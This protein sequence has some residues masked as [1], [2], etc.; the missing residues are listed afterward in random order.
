MLKKSV[1][2]PGCIKVVF[3]KGPLGYLLQDPTEE[4]RVIKDNPALQDKSAPKKEELVRQDALAVVRQRGGDASDK[5]EVL[6]E[7]ILQ[8]GKYKGKSFRWL[9]E[10]DM[11][12]TIYLIKNL[13]QEE[14]MGVFTSEGPSKS[15]LLSFYNY[16]CSFNEIQSLFSYVSKNPGAPAASSEGDQLVGFGAHAKS[17]WQEIWNNR[18]DGYASFILGET[19]VPGTRMY[20]LQQYLRNQMQSARPPVVASSAASKP[21]AS[22]P[23][24]STSSSSAAELRRSA[25]PGKGFYTSGSALEHSSVEL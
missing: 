25:G 18:A 8:F 19:C 5:R 17:T 15:S 11:G 21:T 14:A 12:Y 2:C 16:A 3:R 22:R 10:N 13:Q 6:G 23:L 7:Y 1:F 24:S 9:L 20:K 4:A